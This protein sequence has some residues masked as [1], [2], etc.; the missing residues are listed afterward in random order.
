MK[1]SALVLCITNPNKLSEADV[2]LNHLKNKWD[3][4]EALMCTSGE[5]LAV[6]VIS[7]S[8]PNCIEDKN[9]KIMEI[10]DY[11][12]VDRLIDKV[13]NVVHNYNELIN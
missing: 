6:C 4:R 5:C 11:E 1:L 13:Y 2:Y 12:C 3:V 9:V 10:A 8:L 7:S